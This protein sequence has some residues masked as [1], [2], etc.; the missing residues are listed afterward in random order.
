M[1]QSDVLTYSDVNDNGILDLDIYFDFLCPFSYQASL[2]VRQISNL[3]GP[4]VIS[5]R[6]RFFSLE[7]NYLGKDK[8][9]WKIWEQPPGGEIHGLLAFAAGGAAHAIGGEAS[10]DSFYAAL[11]KM[12]HEEGL[13]IWERATLE[14]AWQTAGLEPAALAKVLDNPDPSNYT[15][16]ERDHTEAVE[17]Y[18]AFGTPT[19]VF[20][21]S[22]SFYLALMPAPQDLSDAL[23]LFQHVQRM[24]MGFGLGMMEFKQTLTEAQR[25]A[26]F[27]SNSQWL[28]ARSGE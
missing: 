19:L 25:E 5:I 21:E 8:P 27:A 1:S 7:Q 28:Q 18:G 14:K 24:A 3:M 6:W 26:H 12:H 15:K 10:L 16:L 20:E 11:G 2:W 4:E 22:H 13:P 17:K 23:E 9:D